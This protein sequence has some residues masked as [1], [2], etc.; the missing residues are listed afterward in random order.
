MIYLHLLLVS[1]VVVFIVDLSGFTDS[2]RGFLQRILKVGS[3]KSIKPFDCSLCMTWWVCIIYALAMHK[4]NIFTV[5]YSALLSWLTIPM[6]Q[7]MIF[8][9]EWLCNIIGKL[10]PR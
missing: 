10:M 4:F 2:W 7:M 8:L 3:L 1:A 9:K 6:G 5:A